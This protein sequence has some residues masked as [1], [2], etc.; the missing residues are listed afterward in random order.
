MGGLRRHGSAGPVVTLPDCVYKRVGRTASARRW[1]ST[2]VA[3]WRRWHDLPGE[4]TAGWDNDQL[5]V[6]GA[7]CEGTGVSLLEDAQDVGDRLAVTWCGPTPADHDTLTDIGRCE[8][9]L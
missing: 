4:G 7:D 1:A 2:A 9:D 5:P 8:P 3:G 6:P